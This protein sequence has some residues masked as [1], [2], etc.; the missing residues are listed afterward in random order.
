[1][2]ASPPAESKAPAPEAERRRQALAL[3]RTHAMAGLRAR[4]GRLVRWIEERRRRLVALRVLRARPRLVLDV[5]CEDGWIAAG[6]ADRV[7]RVVL[8][9]LDPEALAASPLVGRPNVERVVADALEPGALRRHLGGARADVIVLSAL[10]EHLHEPAAA[11]RALAGLLAPG[12]VFVVYVPADRPILLLK[13]LLKLT[14]LG[15]LVKGLSLEPA[16]GH[17]QTFTRPRL[18]RLLA[19][20]GALRALSF[21]PAALGYVAVLRPPP[22]G[23]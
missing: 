12:G 3:N 11:L 14:R 7:E 19:A 13:R 20:Q 21:D 15:G 22:G 2:P 1:M 5:G 9:D 4:G 10:L 18:R 8:A 6:Y 16:P 23:G 17:V